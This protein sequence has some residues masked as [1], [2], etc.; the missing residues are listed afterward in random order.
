M[1]QLQPPRWT[2][3]RLEELRRAA[4]DNFRD[5]RIN[6]S[7]TTYREHFAKAHAAATA[8]MRGSGELTELTDNAVELLADPELAECCRYLSA[9]PI[10]TDDL[11]TIAE[12]SMAPGLLREEPERA[13]Q[14]MDTIALTLDHARFPWVRERRAPSEAE[15]HTATTATAA[16]LASRQVET[17]RRNEGKD[18]QESRVRG[19]LTEQCGYREV[20]PREITN[21]SKAPAPGQFCK[22]CHVGSRKA[23]VAV[24]LWDGRLMPIECKVSNSTTN[25]YKRINNDAAVK[26]VAWRTEFGEANIVPAATLSGVFA[27]RNL[28]YAQEKGLTLFWAHDLG[29][30][31]EFIAQTSWPMDH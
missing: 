22:E 13:K 14:L 19:Y 7:E 17:K 2:E 12:V 9:P 8:I 21:L 20:P 27:L 24:G 26:A 18:Q 23:D 3:E 30:L 25:S 11:E 4:K 1:P 16:L 10:S 28:T 6:E 29:S 5:E 15:R 31:G